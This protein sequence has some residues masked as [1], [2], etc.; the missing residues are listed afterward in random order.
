MVGVDEL[1]RVAAVGQLGN[2][3]GQVD[4]VLPHGALVV[5]LRVP[6]VLGDRLLLPVPDRRQVGHDIPDRDGAIR[7]RGCPALSR[8]N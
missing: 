1:L 3:V 6:V 2:D 5:G 7:G 8:K 4:G